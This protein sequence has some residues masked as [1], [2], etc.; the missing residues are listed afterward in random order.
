MQP[1]EIQ[2]QASIDALTTPEGSPGVLPASRDLTTVPVGL[3]DS[4]DRVPE[5]R[6]DRVAAARE[7]LAAGIPSDSDLAGRMVGR[8]VCDRLR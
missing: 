7:R 1:T 8:I 4:L 6:E 2:V 5:V 3:L